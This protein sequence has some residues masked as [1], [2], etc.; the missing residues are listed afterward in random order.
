MQSVFFDEVNNLLFEKYG[1]DYFFKRY[2]IIFDAKNIRK[3]I[4]ETESN[5]NKALLNQEVI[6][7]LNTEAQK[8]YDKSIKEYNDSIDSAE[9]EDELMIAMNQWKLPPNYVLAQSLLADELIK[10]DYTDNDDK[11]TVDQSI[12][13][14]SEYAEIEQFFTLHLLEDEVLNIYNSNK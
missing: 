1:W 7:Y 6:L 9:T 14:E 8:Q 12:D 5:L 10:V 2:K 11:I 13:L 3:A 4:P